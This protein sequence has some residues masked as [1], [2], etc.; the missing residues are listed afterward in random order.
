MNLRTW[1]GR[2]KRQLTKKP[3][4][5]DK[6]LPGYWM[7]NSLGNKSVQVVQIGSNDGKT[8]DPFYPI[9]QIHNKWKGL[10]VE[11]VPYIF[12]KLK[13]NYPDTN[14]F[15]FE[16]V[17]INQGAA[18]TFYWVD[19]K[20]KETLPELPYWY[21]QLGSFDRD[22]ILKLLNGQ[23]EPFVLESELEGIR[24]QTLLD[25]ND[26]KQLDILHLDTEGYDWKILSQLNLNKYQPYFILFEYN[27]L[28]A[29]DQQ[30]AHDFLN[31]NYHLY[32]AGIDIW[33]V[34]KKLDDELIPRINKYIQSWEPVSVTIN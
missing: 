34:S 20:A 23:L 16:N 17:A 11:P 12:E 21:N 3:Y 15:K 33:A 28:S 13:T 2:I 14:R 25:R 18:L 7:K 26:I 10:F 24:L 6:T 27:H 30:A 4:L 8:G 29:T 19:P 22:H 9:F 31:T 1:L 5:D 32:N